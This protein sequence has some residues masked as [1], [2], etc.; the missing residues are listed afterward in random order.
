[1]EVKQ[2]FNRY[3]EVKR[4]SNKHQM[5]IRRNSDR[6][7]IKQQNSTTAK[8]RNGKMTKQNEITK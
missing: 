1:M 4:T 7:Q 5:D 6:C 8:Q 2:T 3:Q